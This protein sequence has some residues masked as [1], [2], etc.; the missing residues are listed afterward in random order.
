[1]KT[2]GDCNVAMAPRYRALLVNRGAYTVQSRLPDSTGKHY[3]HRPDGRQCLTLN[4]IQKH[5]D[6]L[7][8]IGLYA[9]DPRTQ[10][11][12]WLALDADYS[13]ALTDLMKIRL[14]MR[15]DGLDPALEHSR[16]GAHL[17]VFGAEPL[18]A[19]NW[20]VYVIN[21][22]E[23][24]GVPIKFGQQ[25]GI[26][27]FPRHDELS[28]EKFGNAIR[29]PLGVH[30]ATGRRYWFYDAPKNVAAQLDYLSNRNRVTCLL[31]Q[32]LI[33][34][35][36]V[37]EKFA[38]KP[39]IILRPHDPSR[40]G[41]RI[42]DYVRGTLKREGRDFRTRCPSCALKGEDKRGHRLAILIADPRV[43]HCWGGCRKEEIRAALGCPI[44]QNKVG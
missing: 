10:T 1:M 12:K 39:E 24:M 19:R 26:E 20:R 29:G 33:A 38:P 34:G 6:G 21:L 25:E 40:P 28:P 4:V 23:R 35:L 16:R 30:R 13:C 11:S 14:A 31:L 42:L 17:W 36:T 43:Y 37:P 41:F 44:R 7:L 18:P 15:Q 9:I 27:I 5:L 22:A 2:G 3:Y 32:K 8:T